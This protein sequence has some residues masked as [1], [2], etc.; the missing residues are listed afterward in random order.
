MDCKKSPLG[1]TELETRLDACQRVLLTKGKKLLELDPLED[2]EAVL[3]QAIGRSGNLR[4][5]TLEHEGLMIIG[6][7]EEA[8]HSLTTGSP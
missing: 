1:P 4:A 3:A 2:R 6:F 8:Y 7:H 5:P